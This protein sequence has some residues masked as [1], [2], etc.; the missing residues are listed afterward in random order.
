[1]LSILA[2]KIKAAVQK[3]F[4][5]AGLHV[6]Q[7]AHVPSATWLGLP[8]YPIRSIFDVG[9]NDGTFAR[10]ELLSRFPE[11]RIFCVE[12]QAEP[13][14][15]LAQWAATKED[16]VEV[17]NC[18]L[19]AVSG[20]V[21]FL[22]HQEHSPSSSVLRTTAHAETLYPFK[23]RQITTRVPQTTLDQLA[24]E[25][26]SLEDEIFV[27]IDVQGYEDR[28]IAGGINLL[29]RCRAC[30][31]E[32]ILD[33]LYEHQASFRR[34]V[35]MLDDLGLRYAGNVAQAIGECGRVIYLDALFIRPA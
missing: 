20:T 12:P 6:T 22:V 5:R 30:M 19:G 35:V 29:S 34:L 15:R 31:I 4:A 17:F 18:A 28:V 32:I 21:E 25:I 1:M 23:I 11:A 9:A 10:V 14:T 16:K 27:K 2:P 26:K 7:L 13:F 8:H 33:E 24:C 3:T